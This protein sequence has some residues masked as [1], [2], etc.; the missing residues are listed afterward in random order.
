MS[1]NPEKFLE[2]MLKMLKSWSFVDNMQEEILGCEEKFKTKIFLHIFVC[3]IIMSDLL[4]LPA[5]GS[6][7]YLMWLKRYLVPRRARGVMEAAGGAAQ[8]TRARP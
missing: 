2:S 8:A 6:V 3:N 4:C 1:M 7:L 5:A